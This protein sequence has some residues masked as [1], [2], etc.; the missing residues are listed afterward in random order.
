MIVKEE[1]LKKLKMAFDLN[2]YEVKIWTSLL[3]KGV[4]AAGELS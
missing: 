3:S 2:E 1:F 4:A